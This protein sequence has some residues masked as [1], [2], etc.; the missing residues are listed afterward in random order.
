MK[1]ECSQTDEKYVSL[2]VEEANKSELLMKHGCVAVSGGK[3]VGRGCNTSRTYSKDGL[4]RNCC[5]CHAEVNVM[6]QCIKND[7]TKLTLYIVRVSSEGVIR[8]SSPCNMCINIMK[9]FSVKYIIY[10]TDEGWCKCK[11]NEYSKMFS[12]SGERF[13]SSEERVESLKRIVPVFEPKSHSFYK[14]VK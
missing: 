9:A 5:S 3:I 1:H 8:N 13:L 4:I 10:S 11:V 2:A 7:R 14:R 6:R 12:C